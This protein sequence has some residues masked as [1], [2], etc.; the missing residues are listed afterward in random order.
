MPRRIRSSENSINYSLDIFEAIKRALMRRGFIRQKP[1]TEKIAVG[2]KKTPTKLAGV[3][4]KSHDI[5]FRANTVF[6]FTLFPDTVTIDREK[7]TI[8]NREFF[9]VAKIISVPIRDILNVEVD[10]GPFLG[11]VRISSRFF[12]QY[13]HKVNFLWRGDA[14]KLQRLLEGYIIANE[15]KIDCKDIKKEELIILLNDLG[16][17]DTD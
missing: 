5:L 2:D 1:Q 14:I 17:G 8:V 6:P 4:V 16:K 9:L 10:M 12:D 15:Q 3:T 13:H 11:S 7:I